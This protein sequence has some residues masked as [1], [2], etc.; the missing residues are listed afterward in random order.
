MKQC[1]PLEN[2]L[3]LFFSLLLFLVLLCS[4]HVDA[5]VLEIS[6]MA[7][8]NMYNSEQQHKGHPHHQCVPMSP[9][10]SFSNDFVETQ[11]IINKEIKSSREA[12]SSAAVSSDFEFSVS[13]FSMMS[14]DELFCK[15]KLLP[16]K[17][18]Q[19]QRTLRDELLVD[20]DSDEKHHHHHQISLRP[21]KSGSSSS[22][23]RWRGLLGLR[24]THIGS[25]KSDSETKRSIFAYEDTSVTKSSSTSSH[26]SQT[27]LII[28]FL[29]L[30]FTCSHSFSLICCV[31]GAIK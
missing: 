5:V 22:S 25:K 21:P 10:I 17:E 15:G 7:C 27:S 3:G 26:V 8:L 23:T 18:N 13:N 24:R 14:A 31:S 16:F 2:L 9:R 4:V 1:S 28:T 29:N 6:H 30:I 20:D 12:S 19:M 11:H